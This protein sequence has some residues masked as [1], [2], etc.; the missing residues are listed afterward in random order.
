MSVSLSYYGASSVPRSG[1]YRRAEEPSC[2]EVLIDAGERLPEISLMP[3]ALG[4]LH[5]NPVTYW[6]Y[7][8]YSG[9]ADLGRGVARGRCETIAAVIGPRCHACRMACGSI[10]TK[11]AGVTATETGASRDGA[12]SST[13]YA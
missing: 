1:Q 5:S 8:A 7:A 6:T 9:K 11:P 12:P 10:A 13:G 3:M 2:R 4:P